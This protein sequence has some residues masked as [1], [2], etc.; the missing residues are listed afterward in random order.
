M[1]EP[2]WISVACDV[3]LVNTVICMRTGK[4]K[5]Y[6]SVNTKGNSTRF[7]MC[8]S[9]TLISNN[10]CFA[11]LWVKNG[12]LNDNLCFNFKAQG[13]STNKL[14]YFYNILNEFSIV[15]SGFPIL[16]FQNGIQ[17]QMVKVYKLF[18]RLRFRHM[19]A[20]SVPVSGTV[21]CTFNKIKV[22]VGNNIFFCRTG[23]YILKPYTCDGIKD[24]PYDN[25]D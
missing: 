12:N 21:I 5:A 20:Q 7:Y 9:T 1:T 24:C 17:L 10:K 25:S 23:G 11:F 8:K 14:S 19:F 15:H 3:N 13:V 2:D 6:N 22:S 18:N 16:I 4:Y